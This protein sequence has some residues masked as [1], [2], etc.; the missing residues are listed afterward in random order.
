MALGGC[1]S[2][3]LGQPAPALESAVWLRPAAARPP[4]LGTTRWRLLAFFSPH[5]A[6]CLAAVPRLVRLQHE[7]ADDGLTVI[8][9]TE[10][11]RS[12]VEQFFAD[13]GATYP[14]LCHARRDLASYQVRE[15]PSTVLVAPGGEI[16]AADLDEIEQTLSREFATSARSSRRR[17]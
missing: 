9:V 8:G 11:T 1:A 2:P 16:V 14:V 10:A 17:P 4:N 6:A 15:V 13:S 5:S 7:H 12:E 3:M